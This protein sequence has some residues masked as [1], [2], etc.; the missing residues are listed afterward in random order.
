[1]H[2]D[3]AIDW[4]LK[5]FPTSLHGLKR[6]EVAAKQ[7]SILADDFPM[8][9]A[10]IKD[11]A[12]RHNIAWMRAFLEA[13]S[14]EIC[15]HG[16]TTMSPELFAL[17]RENGVWGMTAATAHHV[18][19]YRQWGVSRI[20]LANQL[21]SPGDMALIFDELEK[22]AEFEFFCLL[23]SVEGTDR[24]AAAARGRQLG[25]RLN[26]L[27]EMGAAQGRTGVRSVAGGTDLSAHI[28]EQQ[29]VLALRGVE[30]FEGIFS[31]DGDGPDQARDLLSEMIKLVAELYA[32]GHFAK[33]EILLTGGGSS[34]FDLCA[35]L[36]SRVDLAGRQR[37]ILRSGC[38]IVHDHGT[39]VRAFDAI[40][41]RRPGI[42]LIGPGPRA[43]LEVWAVIQSVPAPGEAIASLGKRD[44][45]FDADL[46]VA[47]WHYRPQVDTNPRPMTG[48]LRVTKLYDQHACL[49]GL[50]DLKVGDLIGFG[51]SH[52][53]TT[54]DKWRALP[55]LDDNYVMTSFVT[56]MF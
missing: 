54:F 46:P 24:L 21:V 23:D 27:I 1:M 50:A 12:I 44:I 16:K 41:K 45:G 26:V 33:G 30:I 13:A 51:V 39:Y 48:T 7:A 53:C 20:L 42:D 10:I 40:R 6:A 19:I 37:I 52:P 18:R 36:L 55:V 5:G 35:E 4:R 2:D 8:P 14:V 3:V 38:Y 31:S 34:L 32:A 11:S 22:D 28:M 17:Q 15:P 29:D 43:A 25:R 47:I 49:A 9:V 56:T